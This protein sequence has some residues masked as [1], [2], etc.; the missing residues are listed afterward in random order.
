MAASFHSNQAGAIPDSTCLISSSWSPISYQVRLLCGLQQQQSFAD[1][2][3]NPC[4]TL[5]YKTS[6]FWSVGR[7][8]NQTLEHEIGSKNFFSVQ[9]LCFCPK[10]Y[11]YCMTTCQNS[12]PNMLYTSC[13]TVYYRGIW[14]WTGTLVISHMEI[15]IM[16]FSWWKKNLEP[17]LRT[18]SW[19]FRRNVV[20][21]VYRVIVKQGRLIFS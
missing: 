15:L 2:I 16:R 3:E 11:Y 12:T 8:A 14:F 5:L 18:Q 19:D 20:E 10:L 9:T 1:K 7:K 4:T 13:G 6:Q 17:F 21:P